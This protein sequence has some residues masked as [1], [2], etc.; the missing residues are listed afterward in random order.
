MLTEQYKLRKRIRLIGE[1]R[2]RKTVELV[3]EVK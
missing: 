1:S 2:L 3:L